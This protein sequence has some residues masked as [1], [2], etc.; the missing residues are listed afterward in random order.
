VT[1]LFQFPS[2]RALSSYFDGQKAQ[3]ASPEITDRIRKQRAA[4]AKQ[5]NA[6]D[7]NKVGQL[8]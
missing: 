1:D 5:R 8:R 2:V 3:V 7:A 6:K 4:M